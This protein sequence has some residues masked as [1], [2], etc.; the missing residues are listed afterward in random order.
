MTSPKGTN[1]AM[2]RHQ[3]FAVLLFFLS[4]SVSYHYDANAAPYTGSLGKGRSLPLLTKEQGKKKLDK[5]L[6]NVQKL[7]K[8]GKP[9]EARAL[10]DDGKKIAE[11]NRGLSIPYQVMR[12]S[13][14]VSIAD[15]YAAQ[16][17]LVGA[18]EVARDAYRDAKRLRVSENELACFAGLYTYVDYLAGVGTDTATAM[19][20][21]RALEQC[22]PKDLTP[23]DKFQVDF[24]K[25]LI[26]GHFYK[27]HDRPTEF[28]RMLN[29][30]EKAA[31][32]A[33]QK[34][35]EGV[36]DFRRFSAEWSLTFL[37]AISGDHERTLIHLDKAFDKFYQD[38][39][40]LQLDDK[41]RPF[42][43]R[44]RERLLSYRHYFAG[45]EKLTKSQIKEITK[46]FVADSMMPW[47]KDH[48][49]A[50]TYI[51]DGRYEKAI[52]RLEKATDTMPA[53]V[54]RIHAYNLLTALY[55][56]EGR[57]GQVLDIGKSIL[58]EGSDRILASES[59][60]VM[61]NLMLQ[62]Y[63]SAAN[64]FSSNVPSSWMSNVL[65]AAVSL[66]GERRLDIDGFDISLRVGQFAQG[67]ATGDA[68][69][70]MVA[71]STAG[72]TE[73]QKLVR[74]RQDV[75][76]NMQAIEES[77]L[78]PSQKGFLG[79][80]AGKDSLIQKL[81]SKEKRLVEIDYLLRNK[82]PRY[83][84]AI[85]F[86]PI[87]LSELQSLLREDEALLAYVVG[88]EH[89][90][91]W[92]VRRNLGR[93]FSINITK[94]QLRDSVQRILTGLT[95]P[96]SGQISDLP[97]FPLD[98]AY[99]LYGRLIGPAEGSLSGVTHLVI[100]PDGEL[101]SLPFNTL[102][103]AK[104]PSIR[105]VSDY[106]NVRWLA[107]S[108][109][110]S[111]LPS[112]PSL[113]ALR[114]E[115][116]GSGGHLPFLGFGDPAF[117]SAS[118]STRGLTMAEPIG[119]TRLADVD[120]LNKLPELPETAVELQEIANSLGATEDTVYLR[121]QATE[122][123][124]KTL[125]LS[126][127][128]VVAFA[129]HALLA[130]DLGLLGEPALVLTPPKYEKPT[131][132]GLLTATEILDLK[133]DADWVILSA[134]NTAGPDGSPDAPGLSGLAR[135]FFFSGAR[136]LLVSYWPVLSEPAVKLT[137]GTIHALRDGTA[138]TKPEALQQSMLKVMN[139]EESIYFSHPMAW[140]PFSIVGD[141]R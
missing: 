131:D 123:N 129:T 92:L 46:S 5:L 67:S 128:R 24:A 113:R 22:S 58:S 130:G 88:V 19:E 53:S 138:S 90:Y 109:A 119:P 57:S 76:A 115:G 13:G 127:Y 114:R 77:L 78:R 52:D 104:S 25:T 73:V 61:Q 133:L 71:R 93:L 87:P 55:A 51:L 15:A 27:N 40:K 134:C 132:D 28:I 44:L 111:V 118:S 75:R 96:D 32:T 50:L 18:A 42:D 79:S 12:I 85:Q 4:A 125:P 26:L 69:R 34:E 107:K 139:S 117:S 20:G 11:A 122:T 72:P 68:I 14:L 141:S 108:Y 62:M 91:L 1:D 17:N 110:V 60:S 83:S 3:V 59:T 82:F 30:L 105:Q 2:P 33:R 16:G 36:V 35:P 7:A 70:K 45:G 98:A 99:E 29:R 38:N 48:A 74:E 102:P 106:A 135:A 97:E 100:V 64:G 89:T 120:V 103:T 84:D 101:F 81:E 95:P 136:S 41:I 47:D 140:A 43:R 112:V 54:G 23:G 21:I 31:R 66:G 86:N 137:T 121:E 63:L 56:R 9:D 6:A 94:E 116:R 80:A 37:Y 49:K 126:D 10:L 39:L 8:R 124:V 65:E